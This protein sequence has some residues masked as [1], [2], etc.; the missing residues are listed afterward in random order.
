MA[1]QI[2]VD[3]DTII[4]YNYI[5]KQYYITNK[6]TTTY[7][8]TITDI[9]NVLN[10]VAPDS[11]V[12]ESQLYNLSHTYEALQNLS[13]T[14]SNTGS[15]IHSVQF[16]TYN[17]YPL[18]L[19]CFKSKLYI[20]N[21]NIIFDL[22]LNEAPNS[23]IYVIQ[24]FYRDFIGLLI[25]LYDMEYIYNL[26]L[27]YYNSYNTN[28]I[29]NIISN[30]D[31]EPL[32]YS[33]MFSISNWDNKQEA[34]YIC[35]SNPN[36]IYNNIPVLDIVS[37]NTSLNTITTLNNITDEVNVGDKI[38]VTGTTT[39]TDTYSYSADGEYI[40]SSISNNVITTTEQILG[41]YTFNFPKTYL[42]RDVCIIDSI[43]R[44]NSTITLHD[45]V[46]N[47]IQIGDII[48]VTGTQQQVQSQTLTC[49]GYYTV[50][51]IQNKIITVQEA[52]LT[53]F[54][55]PT[56]AATCNISK[57]LFISNILSI[58]NNTILLQQ[59]NPYTLTDNTSKIVVDI[60]NTLTTYTVTGHTT[61]T[62]QVSSISSYN[63]IYPQVNNVIPDT[64][65]QIEV[66][67]TNNKTIFPLTT[68][69]VDNFSEVQ[70]YISLLPNLPVPDTNIYNNILNQ[71]PLSKEVSLPATPSIT[72]MDFIGI[73]DNVYKDIVVEL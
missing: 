35:T 25:D 23:R 42:L 20:G 26:L 39:V 48:Y 10:I 58:N 7:R 12:S 37:T 22:T 4:G 57:H 64:S 70:Q 28:N 18:V 59:D 9:L 3:T 61:D 34:V 55:N 21:T 38:S 51:A 41:N 33:N 71:V 27:S 47:S 24:E 16:N 8:D 14:L 15:Y 5:L 52:P 66:T 13:Y 54:E 43:S 30:T 36:N 50:G 17:K 11:T 46:P 73:F 56:H 19:N 63:P 68:F 65:I 67:S 60:N 62:I 32:T 53:N 29:Y 69:I 31:E 2:T 40:I 45:T 72:S 49:D 1:R 6:A 44:D